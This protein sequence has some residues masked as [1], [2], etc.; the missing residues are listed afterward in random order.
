MKDQI[1]EMKVAYDDA[2]LA[3]HQ[4]IT[5]AAE[6]DTERQLQLNANRLRDAQNELSKAD[7]KAGFISQ[8]YQIDLYRKIKKLSSKVT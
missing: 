4:Y 8:E 6:V 7:Y 1:K 2:T 3:A 5:E